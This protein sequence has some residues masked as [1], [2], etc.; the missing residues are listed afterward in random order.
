MFIFGFF[1][2]IIIGIIAF[3]IIIV[4]SI[5]TSDWDFPKDELIN[6]YNTFLQSF[7]FVGLSKDKDLKGERNFGV[8]EYVGTYKAEY[9]N[10]TGTE[11]VFGGTALHRK[12]GDHI[13]LTIKIEKQ[14]GNINVISKLG[15]NELSLISGNGEYE[16]T[17]YIDGM[18]YYLSTN[19]DNF[20]GSIYIISE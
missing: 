3:I 1:K 12:N 17:I 14:S 8:D 4:S 19:L 11:T 2:L 6:T 15:E 7:D 13:K 18:S 20:K 10:Y 5:A 9:D 16:D